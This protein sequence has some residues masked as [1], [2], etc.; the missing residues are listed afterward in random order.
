MIRIVDRIA[1]VPKMGAKL[2]DEPLFG[3]HAGA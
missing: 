1:I 2:V 3:K